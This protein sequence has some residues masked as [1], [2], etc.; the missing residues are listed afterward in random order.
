MKNIFFLVLTIILTASSVFADGG[1]ITLDGGIIT[2]DGGIIT[3]LVCAF[4]GI[5][6]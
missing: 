2:L 1:I 4:G 3:R 6:T 5:I